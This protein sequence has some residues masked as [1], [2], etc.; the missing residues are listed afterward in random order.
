MPAPRILL[1]T[2]VLFPPLLRNLLLG[3]AA[4]GLYQP[5]WS[6]MIGAEWLHLAAQRGAADAE[7]AARALTRMQG[8]WPDGLVPAGDV[9]HLDLPD[10]GDRHVLAAAIAGQADGIVTAN[11]R[12]FPRRALAPQG[13]WAQAPDDFVMQHWLAAPATVEAEVAQVWPGLAGADLRRALKK[14]RL[15]RLGKALAS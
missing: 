6:A 11:L 4:R 3:L 2:C 7:A 12:D 13:L 1:D 5:L 10:R 14:A 8:H 9:A 15:P